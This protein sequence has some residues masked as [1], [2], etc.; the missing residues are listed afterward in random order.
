M[1]NNPML[2]HF[3][4]LIRV[5]EDRLRE[6]RLAQ[7]FLTGEM[8]DYDDRLSKQ[9]LYHTVAVLN[10]YEA[11]LVRDQQI[12][13]ALD[14]YIEVWYTDQPIQS[15][16][17]GHEAVREVGKMLRKMNQSDAEFFYDYYVGRNKK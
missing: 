8:L 15:S 6:T 3:K 11:W 2:E 17:D 10:R 4:A 1:K 14:H 13:A 16:P 9:E 12:N 5:S 7:L